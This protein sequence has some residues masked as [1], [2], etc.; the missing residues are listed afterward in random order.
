MLKCKMKC[1]VKTGKRR[2]VNKG[3][4]LCSAASRYIHTPCSFLLSVTHFVCVPLL[5]QLSSK[6]LLF[7]VCVF[8]SVGIKSM[9]TLVHSNLTVA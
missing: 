9:S 3:L 1:K 2:E 7:Y 6:P 4:S 5:A 8:L